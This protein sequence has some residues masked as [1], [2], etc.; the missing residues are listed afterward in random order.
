M[1][2]KGI[3]L[4]IAGPTAT[5][6]VPYW[7]AGSRATEIFREIRT[8]LEILHREGGYSAYDG[9]LERILDLGADGADL[10]ESLAAY[11]SVVPRMPQLVRDSAG[12]RKPWWRFW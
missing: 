3:Q 5:V 12:D 8:Y 6:T 10:N 2:R 1:R 4:T 9:Q 11:V 7:H